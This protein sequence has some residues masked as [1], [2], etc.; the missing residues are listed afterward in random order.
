MEIKQHLKKVKVE[1]IFVGNDRHVEFQCVAYET[2]MECIYLDDG[3]YSYIGRQ[4]S[5]G[6]SEQIV[7]NWL[8]KLAYGRWWKTP[9][10]VG[11][12]SYI[13]QAWLFFPQFKHVL[14]PSESV[15]LDKSWFL[16]DTYLQ[17]MQAW[18]NAFQ[19]STEL[20]ETLDVVYMPCRMKRYKPDAWL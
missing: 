5:Q 1:R 18:L 7:N 6:F 8:K 3:L 11:A 14:I 20:L 19:V 9:K 17:L 10:T 2:G 4:D 12:S 15:S 13:H 16:S